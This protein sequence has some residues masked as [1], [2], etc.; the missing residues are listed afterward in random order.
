MA[1]SSSSYGELQPSKG[2]PLSEHSNVTSSSFEENVITTSLFVVVPDGPESMLV[3][4]AVRSTI[5]HVRI[6][7]SPSSTSGSGSPGSTCVFEAWTVKVCTRNGLRS[8]PV[9]C[10]SVYVT[11]DV[12]T[13]N[14]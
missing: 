3:C 13:A 8:V 9:S 2:A 10:A 5:S 7:G 6:A 4:G 12:Q 11:G 14:G 1:L